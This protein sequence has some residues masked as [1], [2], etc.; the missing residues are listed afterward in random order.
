MEVDSETTRGAP[1]EVATPPTG[2]GPS[3]RDGVQLICRKDGA[4]HA[5]GNAGTGAVALGLMVGA[6]AVAH[7]VISPNAL[8]YHDVLRRATY[9]PI[10]LAA[11]WFGTM[12]GVSV[13]L[14]AAA[15]AGCCAADGGHETERRPMAHLLHRRSP[16]VQT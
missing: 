10:V 11:V 15:R 8:V 14:V 9:I 16:T 12:G 6:I 5:R 3:N 7:Y 2:A 13:A 4:L 1:M